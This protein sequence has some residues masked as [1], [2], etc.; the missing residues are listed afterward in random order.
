ML[1]KRILI[2]LQSADELK[3]VAGMGF[4]WLDLKNP[5]AGSLGCPSRNEADAFY[6]L[7]S[8]TIDRNHSFLSIAL[9]ELLEEAWTEVLPIA[10]QFDFVKV[11]L[12]GCSDRDD[13]RER[14]QELAAKLAA[15]N[16]LILVHYADCQLACSPSW[17]ETLDMAVSLE[18]QYILIDTF[19]KRAGRLWDWYSPQ[20]IQRLVKNGLANGVRLSIAGSL[21]IDELEEARTFG[22]EV[23]GV[24]GAACQDG[25]RTNGLCRDRLKQL[26]EL[27]SNQTIT[28]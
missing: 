8:R 9:G 6:E 15:K 10:T 13:W 14:V 4:D 11:A 26:S 12:A 3:T 25:S 16:K 24:R 5:V 27:F 23:I 21:H 22:A 18:S 1:T 7:A 17:N 19:D 28:V 2:S 20:A